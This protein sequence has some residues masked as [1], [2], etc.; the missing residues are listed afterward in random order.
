MLSS[1]AS[2]Q[3]PEIEFLEKGSSSGSRPFEAIQHGVCVCVC[4]RE[5]ERE[6]VMVE[7]IVKKW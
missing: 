6:E 5:R 2:I 3:D 7:K 4:E 1:L